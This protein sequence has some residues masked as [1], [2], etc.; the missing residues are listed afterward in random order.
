MERRHRPVS[1]NLRGD[2]EELLTNQEVG[3]IAEISDGAT[4][5]AGHIDLKGL[6]APT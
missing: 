4:R 1:K 2:S 5:P 3:H 6:G